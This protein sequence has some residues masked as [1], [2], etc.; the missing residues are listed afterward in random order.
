MTERKS[1]E[2]GIL[3]KHL[4]FLLL[5]LFFFLLFFLLLLFFLFFFLFNLSWDIGTALIIVLGGVGFTGLLAWPLAEPLGQLGLGPLLP[6]IVL[7]LPQSLQVFSSD[8]LPAAFVQLPPVLVCAGVSSAL[9]L[10]VHADLG[11]VLAS[12]GLGI[13]S[14]LHGLLSEL[15][16]LPLLE[17][18]EIVVL[19]LLSLLQV[20]LL[21]LEPDNGLPQL[22][23]L[24]LE[25]VVVHG[26]E[27][28]GLDADGQGDLLFLLQLLLGLGHLAA[29]VLNVAHSAV[30]LLDC[31]LGALSGGLLL[32]LL[33]L[34]HGLPLLLSFLQ[35]LPLLLGLLGL[36]VSFLLAQTL[37]LFLLLL[38]QL[39]LLL[40]PDFLPLGLLLLQPLELFLLLGS[41]FPPFVDVLL[42]LLVQLALLGFLA[43]L[44]EV[45][46]SLL[47]GDFLLLI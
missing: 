33:S 38:S 22:G 47:R 2:V 32:L 21:S 24:A 30:C 6:L 3:R 44:E 17:L 45:S 16:L 37:L 39:L 20:V 12:Q 19:P 41:L 27:V 46:I 23:G 1:S 25:L 26:V 14:L 4:F 11:W 5:F 9:V 34:H 29:G 10:G 15:L 43:G 28:E 18:F 13:Q 31:A 7:L 35:T 8:N 42:E 36:L 40:G